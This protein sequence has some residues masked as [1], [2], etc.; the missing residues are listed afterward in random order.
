MKSFPKLR[1]LRWP[2]IP[3]GQLLAYSLM[4]VSPTVLALDILV[5]YGDLH[6]DF[7]LWV[8]AGT[9]VSAVAI[10]WVFLGDMA[11]MAL[12]TQGVEQGNLDLPILR[13]SGVREVARAVMQL[14]R[15]WRRHLQAFSRSLDTDREILENLHDP[16]LL[17]DAEMRIVGINTAARDL[18]GSEPGKR[19]LADLGYPPVI[20]QGVRT[21]LT[22]KIPAVS[23]F[24]ILGDRYFEVRI[25]PI[26][27]LAMEDGWD[28]TVARPDQIAVVVTLH[29]ITES[30]R[31]TAMQQR[32]VA[33]VSHEL[34]TP[35]ASILGFTETLLGPAKND[36]DSRERFLKITHD[37]AE[38]MTR[39]VTDLQQLSQ[40]EESRHLE[41][42]GTVEI[43]KLLTMV[44]DGL[45]LKAL[46]REIGLA[47]PAP[48]GIPMTVKG[49]EDQLYRVFQNL[50]EN[51]IKYGRAGSVVTIATEVSELELGIIIEDQG[52][53]I[54][55]EHLAHL[56]ERFYRADQARSRATGGSGLGLAIVLQTLERHHGRLEIASVVGT[57]ST[58]TVY[59]PLL[60]D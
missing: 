41:V 43:E 38:R 51:A 26:A 32:F 9:M 60:K 47:R 14:D 50:I 21:V 35:L 17:I 46:T 54:S 44:C 39:L 33:N 13:S 53:G 18:F 40:V 56:G 29:E 12:Y 22:T 25:M 10:A 16:L 3:F 19:P 55:E 49:D 42:T 5:F 4:L 23:E 1:F 20:V 15:K 45:A 37:Q 34:R 6:I 24:S 30:R 48:A 59:L 2:L 28:Q 7:A 31:L 8:V 27:A 52:E 11:A 58:F 57:G 36:P